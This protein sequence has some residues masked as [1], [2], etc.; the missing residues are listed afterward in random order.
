MRTKKGL[1]G[2]RR[3]ADYRADGRC[4]ELFNTV[5]GACASF[6]GFKYQLEQAARVKN[7]GKGN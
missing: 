2:V 1:Y 7:T 5:T 3:F 6:P 4:F